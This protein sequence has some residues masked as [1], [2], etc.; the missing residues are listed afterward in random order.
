MRWT[1]SGDAATAAT[2]VAYVFDCDPRDI[3]SPG[4]PSF[5]PGFFASSNVPGVPCSAVPPPA[6]N[7]RRLCVN[8]STSATSRVDLVVGYFNA[9]GVYA[10]PESQ[11]YLGITSAEVLS[12]FVHENVDLL[13]R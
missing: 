6:T 5:C 1:A 2:H 4:Q 11:W 10:T 12:T 13:E 3:S 9:N 7:I 8:V